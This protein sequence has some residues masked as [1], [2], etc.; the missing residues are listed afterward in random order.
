M[1]IHTH[2]VLPLSPFTSQIDEMFKHMFAPVPHPGAGRSYPA[3]RAW[4]DGASIFVE[5]EL[6]GFKM[7][8][9]EIALVGRELSIKGRRTPDFPDGAQ[10]LVNE[11]AAGEFTRTVRLGVPVDADRVEAAL[12]DGV[13]TITLPKAEA[14]LTR[15]IAVKAGDN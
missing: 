13:L 4:Q 12:R 2:R 6:P 8:D 9:L 10:V 14:A 5:A 1:S 11:R 7:E 15:R 3:L